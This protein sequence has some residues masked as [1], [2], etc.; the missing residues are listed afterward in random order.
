MKLDFI[1]LY[2]ALEKIGSSQDAKTHYVLTLIKQWRM[3]LTSKKAMVKCMSMTLNKISFDY[4]EFKI[5][6]FWG[7][8]RS[9]S[10]RNFAYS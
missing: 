6:G 9:L 8:N 4:L 2:R 5:M 3:F 7:V 1:K 10:K